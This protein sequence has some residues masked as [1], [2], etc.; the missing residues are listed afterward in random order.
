MPVPAHPCH[1]DP[2]SP[3]L[4]RGDTT[5]RLRAD[6]MQR[7]ELERALA[8]LHGECWGWAL[9]CSARDRDIAE[10]ALQ[11]AYL[12]VLSGRARF[13]GGSSF[14]TWVF[15]VIRM[16]A[17]EELRRRRRWTLRV[18]DTDS[19]ECIGDPAPGADVTVEHSERSAV[20]LAALGALSPRQREV[21]H[22]VFY[23]GMT[24][25]QAA[26]VMKVSLGSARTHYD[27]GK[28]A[29]AAR[30]EAGVRE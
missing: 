24:I 27:R 2:S 14:R 8:E 20:L 7:S 19:A 17:R 18:E 16:T 25:E 12:R 26:A 15:G 4:T 23:H 21:L 5:F 30:L 10:E 6:G 29:L 9:A 28:K 22:L 13:E 1:M 11:S 3:T